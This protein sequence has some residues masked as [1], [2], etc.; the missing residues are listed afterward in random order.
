MQTG[1]RF[2]EDRHSRAL[3]GLN[4]PSATVATIRNL[5]T[6]VTG[7]PSLEAS[8]RNSS[9][10][11]IAVR[12]IRGRGGQEAISRS[13]HRPHPRTRPRATLSLQVSSPF[14][15]TDWETWGN[16]PHNFISPRPTLSREPH[17]PFTS[18]TTQAE[19]ARGKVGP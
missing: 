13:T 2:R 17:I 18:Y 11:S 8:K 7:K 16:D 6:F 3:G 1:S 12:D 14:Q 10:P 5:A 9:H 19:L 15:V 4:P